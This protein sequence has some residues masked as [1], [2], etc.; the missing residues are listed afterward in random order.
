MEIIRKGFKMH[1]KFADTLILHRVKK[2]SNFFYKFS[3][4]LNCVE[5]KLQ[6]IDRRSIKSMKQKS[7]ACKK[8]G[9]V[10]GK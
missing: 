10:F 4:F 9:D 3:Y 5:N 2:K 6:C 1:F 7:S 8:K